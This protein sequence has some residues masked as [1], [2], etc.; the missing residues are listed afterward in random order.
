MRLFFFFKQTFLTKTFLSEKETTAEKSLLQKV[1]V[2]PNQRTLTMT[3]AGFAFH[4]VTLFYYFF[5]PVFNRKKLSNSARA[6]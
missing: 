6:D 4:H 5:S 1:L 3:I 2:Y